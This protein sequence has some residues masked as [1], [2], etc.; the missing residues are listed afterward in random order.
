M[1]SLL[2]YIIYL[3]FILLFAVGIFYL[4][5]FIISRYKKAEVIELS[6]LIY[7]IIPFLIGFIFDLFSSFVDDFRD[8]IYSVLE[9]LFKFGWIVSLIYLGYFGLKNRNN[10]N[11]LKRIMII[12][13]MFGIIGYLILNFNISEN[14]I[15]FIEDLEWRKDPIG[16]FFRGLFT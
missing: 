1:I 3:P 10:K 7:P 15:S 12:I 14:M 2:L 6:I 8:T 16:R 4:S 11:I 13:I 9:I 5:L